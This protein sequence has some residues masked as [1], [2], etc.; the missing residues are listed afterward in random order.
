MMATLLKSVSCVNSVAPGF[1]S[2]PFRHKIG[3]RMVVKCAWCGKT[4]RTTEEENTGGEDKITHGICG[5]CSA[6]T[7]SGLHKLK[8]RAR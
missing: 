4:I 5:S 7:L 3:A 8:H 2:Q 6:L 1:K